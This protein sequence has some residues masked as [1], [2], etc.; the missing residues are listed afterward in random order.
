MCIHHVYLCTKKNERNQ[1]IHTI[2]HLRSFEMKK[3]EKVSCTLASN[4]R[5]LFVGG[6]NVEGGSV[7]GVW[8]CGGRRHSIFVFVH[9]PLAP[10]LGCGGNGI[11]EMV[12][13][14]NRITLV[15]LAEGGQPLRV[16]LRPPGDDGGVGGRED[17]GQE[18]EDGQHHPAAQV[19]D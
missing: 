10:Q 6:F 16:P 2:S 4:N 19:G 15:A 9:R 8:F 18:L 7:Q 3:K 17:D 1:N 14:A 12:E 5:P 13:T 11:C